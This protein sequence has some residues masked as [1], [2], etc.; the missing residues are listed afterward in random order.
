MW[1]LAGDS[2]TAVRAAERLGGWPGR[3]RGSGHGTCPSVPHG[4]AVPVTGSRKVRR[5]LSF[6]WVGVR[7]EG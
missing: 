6:T 2:K 5:C 3:A 7:V 4:T 1:G